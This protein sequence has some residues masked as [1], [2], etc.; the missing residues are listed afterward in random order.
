MQISQSDLFA[1]LGH[2]FLKD[3]MMAAENV[4]F[5]DGQIVYN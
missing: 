5:E 1:G 2:H 4:S 3:F